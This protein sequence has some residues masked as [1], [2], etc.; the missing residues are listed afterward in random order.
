MK[1][2]QFSLL[3]LFLLVVTGCSCLV[4]SK[5]LFMYV[6]RSPSMVPYK[7]YTVNDLNQMTH[8]EE[9]VI[10]PSCDPRVYELG[11]YDDIVQ[12]MMNLIVNIRNS[13][14]KD[15]AIWIATPGFDSH[16]SPFPIL[17]PIIRN[18]LGN[19][20]DVIR[21]LDGGQY[22]QNNVK[23]IY[24]NIEAV[25]G[26]FDPKNPMHNDMIK[27]ANDL[28]YYV[29][30][31]L[32]KQFLWVPY[33]MLH[34]EIALRIATV[35]NMDIFDR[36]L[37]QPMW[38]FSGLYNNETEV[39]LDWTYWSVKNDAISDKNGVPLLKRNHFLSKIG[40]QMEIDARAALPGT[41]RDRFLQYVAK[42]SEFR[43]KD[44][45]FSFY[46]GAYSDV[47]AILDLINEFY[48]F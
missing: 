38:Y 4:D 10:L 33:L 17:F 42:F 46:A 41:F 2:T 1:Y 15:A 47:M 21:R 9:F 20:S 37:L 34:N 27:L 25:Y 11:P 6:G 30:N 35:S 3:F 40:V 32:S 24:Y 7:P 8:V 23:G 22:W 36:I 13:T 43:T 18:F 45:S 26:T 28:S 16:S 19:M 48:D 14:K 39:N 12:K 44:I 29:H 5:M 31:K